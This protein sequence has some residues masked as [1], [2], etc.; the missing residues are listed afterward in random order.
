M[1]E[2]FLVIALSVIGG[3]CCLGSFDAGWWSVAVEVFPSFGGVPSFS[4][5]DFCSANLRFMIA[6][7]GINEYPMTYMEQ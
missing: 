7:Q 5:F 4:S 2:F 3:A 1:A 6:N